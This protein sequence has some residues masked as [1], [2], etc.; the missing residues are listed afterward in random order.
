VIYE[1]TLLLEAVGY[2]LVDWY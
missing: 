2:D 1:F